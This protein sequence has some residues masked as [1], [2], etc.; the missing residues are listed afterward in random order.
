MRVAYT[1]G[2]C[3]HDDAFVSLGCA[4]HVP[5][6]PLPSGG[7]ACLLDCLIAIRLCDQAMGS[8]KRLDNILVLLI[9]SI[10][11]GLALR[12]SSLSHEFITVLP[13]WLRSVAPFSQSEA[14]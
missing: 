4:Q 5:R 2:V 10:V 6:S 14:Y 8:S 3:T 11:L 9:R 12:R 7:A 13:S 1:S